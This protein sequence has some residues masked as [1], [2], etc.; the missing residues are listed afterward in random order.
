MNKFEKYQ[1]QNNR[2]HSSTFSQI[3]S[4]NTVQKQLKMELI[5]FINEYMSVA[6]QQQQGFDVETT[7]ADPEFKEYLFRT[8]EGWVNNDREFK[9][10]L[11]RTLEGWVNNDREMCFYFSEAILNFSEEDNDETT[12]ENLE[13]F[14]QTTVSS[15]IQQLLHDGR[16]K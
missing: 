14:L 3:K 7:L 4:V 12:L 11:F 2:H 15:V 16:K 13:D 1:P 6:S 9:E 8:L 5:T 10:Y